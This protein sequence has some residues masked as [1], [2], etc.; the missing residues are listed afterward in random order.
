MNRESPK[1]RKRET[2]DDEFFRDFALS[3]F[4]DSNLPVD[5]LSHEPKR[6]CC[7]HSRREE[8]NVVLRHH[9][10]LHAPDLGHADIVL[11]GVSRCGKTPTC[12]YM[13]LQYGITTA[14]YPLVAEDFN[15]NSLPPQLHHLRR[16]LLFWNFWR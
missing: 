13:A 11:G 2:I 14:N 3:G 8:E 16:K 12:L 5:S 15:R 9:N 4:H 1:E 6:I 10:G 7:S